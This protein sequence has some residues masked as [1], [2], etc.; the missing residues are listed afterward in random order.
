MHGFNIDDEGD[1]D[2]YD[3]EMNDFIVGS[4]VS[5]ISLHS[6]QGGVSDEL[7]EDEEDEEEEGDERG[8]GGEDLDAGCTR[9]KISRPGTKSSGKQDKEEKKGR[10]TSKR[11]MQ[12]K[13]KATVAA[14]GVTR[15]RRRLVQANIHLNNMCV[16]IYTCLCT[17]MYV[18]M[19]TR[20]KDKDK[21]MVAMV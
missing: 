13:D 16:Y 15:K 17:N 21:A 6:S 18:Y 19:T 5:E 2:D 4:D 7:E 14:K 8:G 1:S 12:E 20:E 9:G 11:A 3:S 10:K